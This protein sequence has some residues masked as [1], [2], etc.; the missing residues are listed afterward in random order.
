MIRVLC[1]LS[2]RL[3]SAATLAACLVAGPARASKITI[4]GTLAIAA[5]LFGQNTQNPLNASISTI[6]AAG[7]L[8]AAAIADVAGGHLGASASSSIPGVA[9]QGQAIFIIGFTVSNA[10]A[11][12]QLVVDMHLDGSFSPGGGGTFSLTHDMVLSDNGGETIATDAISCSTAK[13][14]DPASGGLGQ[15]LVF[16]LFGLDS[17][18]FTGTL[19][20]GSGPASTS[21]GASADFMNSALTTFTLPA[22]TIINNNPGGTLFQVAGTPPPAVPEPGSL[23]LLGAG[24]VALA[25]RFRREA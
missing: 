17:I 16:S 22:G 4:G 2:G 12:D 25:R 11:G 1:G 7:T 10:E 14:C 19:V 18:T 20:I 15:R 24:V 6:N 3:V 5:G 8:T 9:S 21:Q 23:V 13:P